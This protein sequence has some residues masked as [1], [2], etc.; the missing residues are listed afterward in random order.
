MKG[1]III[2]VAVIAVILSATVI[3]GFYYAQ[4]NN[5]QGPGLI[6]VIDSQGYQTTLDAVPQK[7]VSL[8]P[9]V[10]PILYEIGVGDKVVGVTSYDDAPYDFTAW[11]AAGNMTCV[12]GYS[13]PNLE[14]I[15]SLD[16]D[17]I[18][19]TNINDPYI[20]NLR[21]L[22]HKVVVVGP[23][24]IEGVYQTIELIGKATGEESNAANLVETL[25]DKIDGIAQKI[26]DAHID[27][28]L[29]VYYEVWCDSSGLMSAGAGSWINDVIS[30]AGGINIFG[31]ESQEYPNSSSEVIIQM[32]PD[33]MLFP[34]NMGGDPS[35]GTIEEVKARGGWSVINAVKNN[36]I[37]VLDE[38]I[39]NEPGIKIADQVEVIANCLYPEVF[40][41][42]S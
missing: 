25:S 18:F 40:N 15:A 17:L 6:A 22:G 13:T 19:S 8:A 29:T 39:L 2:I 9:S 26:I 3:Y 23:T 35:Y 12:G 38:D 5:P 24:S 11:F 21:N 30:K 34:T 41:S 10:T 37:Y 33:V 20:P 7:I 28:K 32:N 42:S 16:P 14:A 36:R 4:T 27:K 31:N 1:K